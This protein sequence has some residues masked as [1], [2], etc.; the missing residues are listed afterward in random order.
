[1]GP[2]GSHSCPPGC[3]QV[4]CGSKAYAQTCTEVQSLRWNQISRKTKGGGE[5]GAGQMEVILVLASRGAV[6]KKE[7]MQGQYLARWLAG[8]EC[9]ANGTSS[10]EP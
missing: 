7:K 10:F 3:T 2:D 4:A 6:G 8:G 5:L 9:L 1:M